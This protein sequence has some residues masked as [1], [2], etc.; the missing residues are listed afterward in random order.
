MAATNCATI[1]SLGTLA[2][3][4]GTGRFF[5]PSPKYLSKKYINVVEKDTN[6]FK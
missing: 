6:F 1:S 5:E 3:K 4:L 2:G